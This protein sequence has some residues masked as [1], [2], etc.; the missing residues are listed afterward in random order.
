MEAKNLTS[1]DLAQRTGLSRSHI[2]RLAAGG[3]IPGWLQA[4]GLHFEFQPSEE[5]TEWC[6]EQRDKRIPPV[7]G[8]QT[9]F[10]I[11]IL[12]EKLRNRTVTLYRRGDKD[13]LLALAKILRDTAQS[14]EDAI[15]SPEFCPQK[16]RR[17]D[18]SERIS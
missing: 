7:E 1:M 16:Q 17:R 11:D 12:L 8:Y 10:A 3:K 6:D 9:I 14:I 18:G 5:L 13:M 2:A 15:R 4:D